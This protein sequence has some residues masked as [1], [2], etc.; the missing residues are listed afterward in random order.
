MN[1]STSK[2]TKEVELKIV[3]ALG[4]KPVTHIAQD[5]NMSKPT[6]YRIARDY[7]VNTTYTAHKLNRAYFDNIQTEHQAYWLGFIMADGTICKP[8]KTHI[9]NCRLQINLSAKD[10]ELLELFKKDIEAFDTKIST[11]VPKN[12]YSTNPMCK[13]VLNSKQLCL[14]LKQYGVGSNK[15]GRECIPNISQNLIPHLIR[16]YFD[17]DGSI[18][19]NKKPIVSFTHANETFLYN[20]KN[21][22]QQEMSLLSNAKPI[23]SGYQNGREKHSYQ[24]SFGGISDVLCFYNYI[25]QNATIYLSRKYNKYTSL[26]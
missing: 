13:I 18:S 10:I 15:A 22:L 2:T 21:K 19:C 8:G 7:K 20:L 1:K 6:V 23:P 5:F 17:G 4:T 3:K 25:Y 12:T 16:G 11:Y 26:L 14:G 9:D 24:I